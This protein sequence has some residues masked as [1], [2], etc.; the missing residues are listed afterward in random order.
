MQTTQQTHSERDTERYKK[1]GGDLRQDP[2]AASTVKH[3]NT[4]CKNT[5]DEYSTRR[6]RDT[7][8]VN[9][10]HKRLHINRRDQWVTGADFGR[11]S[12]TQVANGCTV[13][14]KCQPRGS[15]WPGD[16]SCISFQCKGKK[17]NPGGYAVPYMSYEV[18][19]DRKGCIINGTCVAFGKCKDDENTCMKHKCYKSYEFS[20]ALNFFHLGSV[21]ISKPF[22]CKY[23]GKCYNLST[24]WQ[25]GCEIRRCVRNKDSAEVKVIP[26][27]CVINDTCVGFGKF[28]DDENTCMRHNCYK[29][30]EMSPTLK[31]F[32]LV[33]EVVTKPY[34][35]KYNGKC[36]NLSKE[37]Q[38][39][40]ENKRCVRN[41][42]SA[43]VKVIP[44]GCIINATCVGFGK[45]KEDENTCTRHSCYKTYEKSP[46]PF[47]LGS[48][49]LSKPYGCEVNGKCRENG[50]EWKDGCN[51][52]KCVVNG[53]N[54]S[55]TY[56]KV[57][58][59]YGN[60]CYK[61]NETW[62]MGCI[63]MK[64]EGIGKKS[65]V[66][67]AK[68]RCTDGEN[69]RE[70]NEE[71]DEG[72]NKKKCVIKG[73]TINMTFSQ[74]GC[75]YKGKCMNTGQ[76][77]TENC[78]TLKCNVTSEMLAMMVIDKLECK[79][80]DICRK[81][82]AIWDSGCHKKQCVVNGSRGGIEIAEYGT[83]CSN[84][85]LFT[86]SPNPSKDRFISQL[87]IILPSTYSS[88]D[89]RSTVT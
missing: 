62:E 8:H 10:K 68:L 30:Y 28:K 58:C 35:C 49:V 27:G 2:V 32:Q 88:K 20:P 22:G 34:G 47:K 31:V 73:T 72:C 36:Y 81:P 51:T 76:T 69:C 78:V 38:V 19:P 63:T 1:K 45:F 43:E 75:S 64:C 60:K 17:I 13:Q 37:W 40:C 5:K 24:E 54:I 48:E 11:P 56:S 53:T 82:G 4:R 26:R 80:G 57:G 86:D 46:A 3:Q 41:K 23:N 14:G 61:Q 55:I 15:K 21:V 9:I 6:K 70:N 87:Y 77:V 66:D 89:Y 44:R 18:I 74:L 67:Y 59:D 7:R 25:V 71:W 79:D 65:R 42:G 85:L 52:R 12:V 16:S 83:N 33:S 29:K 39:G 50:E 84:M